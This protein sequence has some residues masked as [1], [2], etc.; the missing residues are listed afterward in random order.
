MKK[1]DKHT[2]HPRNLHHGRYNFKELLVSCPELKKYITLNKF[3]NEDTINFAD[4]EAVKFLNKAILKYFYKITDWDIPPNYLCPPIPGRA[5][6]IH[7]AAD[8][9]SE[10]NSGTIPCG[11]KICVLDIGIGANGVY[12]LIGNHQYGWSFVGSD[13]DTTSLASVKKIINANPNLA[14]FIELRHQISFKN[15][16]PNIILADEKFDLTMCNPPFHASLAE[17]RAG[18][19]RKIQNLG[20]IKDKKTVLNFGGQNVELW[21]QGGESAFIKKMIEESVSFSKNCLWFTTLVSKKESLSGVYGEL[22]RANVS[23]I[24]TIEMA[25]GQKISRFVAWTFHSP[26]ERI[27]WGKERWT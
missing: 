4:P 13:I 2:L 16:F 8:L 21:C 12:P 5:D 24:K 19:K 3:N 26:S 25:Q 7:Y 23:E 10:V 9:L 11:K 27:T 22:K 6:Y 20:T 15:I 17:A 1:T 18:T 14:E